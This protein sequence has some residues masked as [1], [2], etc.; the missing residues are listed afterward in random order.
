MYF[1]K[2]WYWEKYKYETDPEAITMALDFDMKRAYI[3][4]DCYHRYY[5]GYAYLE[6]RDGQ[7]TVVRRICDV[8]VD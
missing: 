5:R 3:R 6:K 7:W 2:W 8:C 1:Y 4:Y